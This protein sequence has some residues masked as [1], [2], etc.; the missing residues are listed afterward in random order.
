M[1]NT[2]TVIF[3]LLAL[4]FTTAAQTNSDLSCPKLDVSGGGIALVGE[5]A[6]FT[7]NV[8]T[9]GEN[10]NLEYVWTVD[11]D[12]KIVS[13]QGTNT[14]GV[15]LL[16]EG[17]ITATVEVKGFPES[18][19]NTSSENLGCQL[20]P[21]VSVLVDEFSMPVSQIDKA[22]LAALVNEL[23]KNPG[24]QGYII[25]YFKPNMPKKVVDRKF[26]QISGYLVNELRFE[27]ERITLVSGFD[28][29]Q[30]LTRF[31]I[32]P[33]GAENPEL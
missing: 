22:R 26:R 7:A 15:E 17:N 18:C 20:R 32:V 5:T 31:W 1:K 19:Q 11:G 13:G 12:G 23:Q 8:D 30:F 6:W 4:A 3:S 25:E 21:A 24:A 2:L 27:A 16:S 9:N 29:P 33:P 28:K 10:L 14:I